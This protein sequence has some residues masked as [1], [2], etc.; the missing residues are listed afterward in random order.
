MGCGLRGAAG[1]GRGRTP[2]GT[3]SDWLRCGAPHPSAPM[4][5][6]TRKACAGPRPVIAAPTREVTTLLARAGRCFSSGSGTGGG[7]GGGA[8]VSVSSGRLTRAREPGG[9]PPR[10]LVSSRPA[11]NLGLRRRRRPRRSPSH[12]PPDPRR[13]SGT[14]PQER[15]PSVRGN[16]AGRGRV[17][18]AVCGTVSRAR[19]QAPGRAGGP[20]PAGVARSPEPRVACAPIRAQRPLEPPG[21]QLPGTG[22]PLPEPPSEPP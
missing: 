9:R 8:G 6:V 21:V 15:G 10:S 12:P 5:E 13:V 18:R 11:W 19:R 14:G 16:S 7:G 22:T 4:P 2:T 17:L 20:Q 3:A 1:Q